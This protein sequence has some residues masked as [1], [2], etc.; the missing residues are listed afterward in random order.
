MCN[1]SNYG[2]YRE[3]PFWESFHIVAFTLVELL[4]VIAIIAILASLLLPAL[5]G[6]HERSKQI[7]CANNQRQIFSGLMVYATDNNGWGPYVYW[8]S[9]NAVSSKNLRDYLI[10]A[11]GYNDVKLFAC[12]SATGKLRD[13]GSRGGRISSTLVYSAYAIAF[14][15]SDYAGALSSFYGWSVSGYSTAATDW[16]IKCPRLAML[17]RTIN[18]QYIGVPSDQPFS[19]D[20]ASGLTNLIDAYDIHD[21]PMSHLGSGANTCFMDGHTEWIPKKDFKHYIHYYSAQ[22]RIYW[23]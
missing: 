23:K 3:S 21:G 1:K 8:G 19:G 20:I 7:M 11:S 12:P 16:R 10:P 22:G 14:G 2:K 17:G 15:H 5:K 18:G 6:A 13:G 9:G 4:I